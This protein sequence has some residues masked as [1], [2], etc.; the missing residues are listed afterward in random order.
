MEKLISTATEQSSL[1]F[2]LWLL[3]TTIS[4]SRHY[5]PQWDLLLSYKMKWISIQ[6]SQKHELLVAME[7]LLMDKWFYKNSFWY[8]FI[9]NTHSLRSNLNIKYYC[10]F[11]C[12]YTHLWYCACK[13]LN[14]SL[15]RS[16]FSVTVNL[17]GCV[18]CGGP[19]KINRKIF[20]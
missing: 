9:L 15:I 8:Y 12:Y 1:L 14:S 6:I 19:C 7:T 18:G 13:K 4:H 11:Y 16:Q 5:I 3:T 20:N 17:N 10:Y 2:C